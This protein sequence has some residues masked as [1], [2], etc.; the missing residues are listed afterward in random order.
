MKK[1]KEWI[2]RNNRTRYAVLI[3]F[4]LGL[5]DATLYPAPV[6]TLFVFLAA[7]FP[8]KKTVL[9]L[10]SITGIVS[11]SVIS[12]FIG[13]QLLDITA[14]NSQELPAL[15]TGII[16][17]LTREGFAETVRLYSEWNHWI[18]IFA[19]LTPFPYF[20]FA[21][22]SG[23]LHTNV[24]SF[25]LLVIISQFLKFIL[26]SLFISKPMRQLILIRKLRKR[27]ITSTI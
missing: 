19:S 11:G 14:A 27:S 17:G 26:L 20:L 12:Y 18:L 8:E 9:I 5:V 10:C 4:V 16:P 15:L 13:K 6:A 7:W 23:A 1:I 3:L 24:F 21:L 25:V 22:A 2:I